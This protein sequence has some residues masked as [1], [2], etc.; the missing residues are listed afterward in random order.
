[1][2]IYMLERESEEKAS[3]KIMYSMTKFCL[4]VIYV[5]VFIYRNKYEIVIFV[6]LLYVFGIYYTE[7]IFMYN[8]EKSQRVQTKLQS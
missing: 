6:L 8:Y 5:S 2:Y 3:Y 4:N 7:H 1:M